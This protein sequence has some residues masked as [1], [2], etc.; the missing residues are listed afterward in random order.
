MR[1]SFVSSLLF[2]G[3]IALV[4]SAVEIPASFR[5]ALLSYPAKRDEFLQYSK[6]QIAQRVLSQ[7][8]SKDANHRDLQGTPA[9]TRAS[10][11]NADDSVNF[12]D[13]FSQTVFSVDYNTNCSCSEGTSVVYLPYRLQLRRNEF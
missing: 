13:D 12:D 3:S 2:S 1:I 6:D 9:P 11:C 7:I 5:D 4:E 10:R 8:Q